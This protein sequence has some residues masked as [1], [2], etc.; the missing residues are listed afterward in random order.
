MKK[1][2]SDKDLTF[3][4]FH[5]SR[6]K[7]GFGNATELCKYENKNFDE[8]FNL[9][10]TKGV[11]EEIKKEH[12]LYMVKENDQ[13]VWLQPDLFVSLILWACPMISIFVGK[14]IGELLKT[15]KTEM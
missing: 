9:E 10:M 12:P 4:L 1:K 7:D 11:I 6:S 13:D 8:W 3:Y 5:F 2:S 15:G 14:K